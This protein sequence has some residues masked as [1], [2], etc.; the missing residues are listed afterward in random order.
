[1]CVE[2]VVMEIIFPGMPGGHRPSLLVLSNFRALEDP[3]LAL[4]LGTPFG[5]IE[6]DQIPPR[7]LGDM[8][9]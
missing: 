3:L 7:N 9:T 1:M 6:R 4:E 8:N 2:L 5:A